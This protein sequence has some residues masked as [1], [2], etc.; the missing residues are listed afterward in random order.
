M[1]GESIMEYDVRRLES[2]ELED[3]FKLAL[4]IFMEFEAPDYGLEGVNA[5]KKD[6]I[7]N[8]EFKNACRNGNNRMWGAFDNDKL[9]GIFIMRGVSHISMVFT[10]KEYHRKSVAA[11]I[12][13]QLV[14][15]VK[16][17]NPEVKELTLN[18]S[19]YGKPFYYNMGFTA[20]DDEQTINGI[21]FTP[22]V[23]DLSK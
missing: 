4:R 15:D 13:K 12:F 10:D 5:F 16:K 22:M 19:P 8:E 11:S 3:A 17:Q 9:I 1:Y 23:F 2:C 6:V 14:K 21:R 18:S 7:E 20:T